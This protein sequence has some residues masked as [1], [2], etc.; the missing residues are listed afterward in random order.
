MKAI[1]SF[2]EKIVS[3]LD[4][5]KMSPNQ[6][7][8][9][10][11]NMR[12]FNKDGKG[13]IA[14]VL[15]GDDAYFEISNGFQVIGGAE[16]NGILYVVSYNES[17][18]LGEI[19]SYPGCENDTLVDRYV[20]F[21]NYSDG[22]DNQFTTTLFDFDLE[23]PVSV[24][25]KMS[26]DNSVDLYLVDNKNP[27][28]V[29]NSGF[30]QSGVS[31]GRMYSAEMFNGII[32]QIP[33]TTSRAAIVPGSLV[34]VGGKLKPGNYF[35]YLRYLTID[36][37]PTNFVSEIGPISIL[38]NT[39][40]NS[41]TGLQEKEWSRDQS[42]YT[43][44]KI[45]FAVSN[46]DTTYPYLELAVVRYSSL[47][48]NAAAQQDVF[49]VDKHYSTA[50]QVY[51]D[52]TGHEKEKTFTIDDIINDIGEY[53]ICK[54]QH[55][56]LDRWIGISWKKKDLGYEKETLAGFASLIEASDFH[57]NTTLTGTWPT[58][59]Q[60]ATNNV[61]LVA[62]QNSD[63]I[64]N[65]R[66]Y[67]KG[68][69]YPFAVQFLFQDG[70]L[71]EWYPIKG[72]L[73]TDG[74]IKG[75]YKFDTWNQV[76]SEK[77]NVSQ[78]YISGIQFD[79]DVVGASAKQ[80]I[81]DN[82]MSAVVGFR[83]GRG[84][85]IDNF[86]C[87]G[88]LFRGF[89]GVTI[90]E[91]GGTG[92]W[93]M[94]F[95][96]DEDEAGITGWDPNGAAVLPLLKGNFPVL[97]V[98]NSTEK[99][100]GRTMEQHVAMYPG[101][102]P[103]SPSGSTLPTKASYL[104]NAKAPNNK[105]G[106]YSPDILFEK[107]S[108]VQESTWIET[109]MTFEDSGM[110]S[111][112][113][114][115][116]KFTPGDYIFD[117]NEDNKGTGR[118]FMA[119]ASATAPHTAAPEWAQVKS[120]FVE[121]GQHKG[122]FGFSSYLR[123]I[124]DH[125]GFSR[126]GVDKNRD[127]YVARYLGIIDSAGALSNLFFDN[128]PGNTE[129]YTLVNLYKWKNDSSFYTSVRNSFFP[130]NT[131]YAPISDFIRI[132]DVVSINAPVQ[133]YGGDCF[134]Q[135]TWFRQSR[136]LTLD[137]ANSG[138]CA[139]PTFGGNQA[140][141][142]CFLYQHGLMVGLVTENKYNTAARNEVVGKDA[143]NEYTRYTYFPKV[144][145]DGLKLQEWIMELPSQYLIEAFQ[146]NDGYN[147]TLSD[148]RLY[149]YD[150]LAPEKDLSR[151][152][153]VYVSDQHVSGSY[154]DGYR[155]IS[156]FAFKDYAIELGP[157]VDVQ[158]VL[159]YITIILESGIIQVYVDEKAIQ[160]SSDG[161]IILGSTS[162]FLG[163]RVRELATFGSQHKSSIIQGINGVY[164]IDAR[165]RILWRVG[166]AEGKSGGF[167]LNAYDLSSALMVSRRLN[168][169]LSIHSEGDTILDK[170]PDL[171]LQGQGIVAGFDPNYKEVLFSFLFQRFLNNTTLVFDENVDGF[172]GEYSFARTAYFTLNN[173][174]LSVNSKIENGLY[175]GDKVIRKHNV[176]SIDGVSN[177]NRFNGETPTAMLTFVVNGLSENPKENVIA[178][179]KIFES[180]DVHCKYEDLYRL[181]YE[182]M[183]QTGIYL[184]QEEGS[185]FWFNSEYDLNK[186]NIPVA[187]QTSEDGSLFQEE[188]RMKGFW[189]KI[190][191]E[192]KG[193]N[194]LEIRS[195]ATNFTPIIS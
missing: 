85:R 185:E 93:D 159:D 115:I 9:P 91:N 86:I 102:D 186:W 56:F 132:D 74:E 122:K 120:T 181:V 162:R 104:L 146:I 123:A 103:S 81:L 109:L 78:K 178:I 20:P 88:V 8:F 29:I 99:W 69:I 66:G 154:I 163:D 45:R 195:V 101:L 47:Q 137:E 35:L 158:S 156:S 18:G 71:S 180:I 92:S 15:P 87:Q 121:T 117:L 10:T 75:L 24:L 57:E 89:W 40:H 100:Y 36:Y 28:R 173:A 39:G 127:I 51:I 128:V 167:Y 55:Q 52:Y 68:Q 64:L 184:F 94:T 54:A 147:K 21:K 37:A 22:T 144:L 170:W 79:L 5:S 171:P 16:H 72:Q 63:M 44:K 175:K 67:F 125:V 76:A 83:F 176:V 136:W 157:M 135:K 60:H 140:D 165:K 61:S 148:K 183:Y 38:N 19:G 166:R 129:R 2:T 118:I 3:D 138:E 113:S 6:W 77:N 193:N 116:D 95:D 187:V 105:L 97:T 149:G 73:D 194:D 43:D 11:V 155:K 59:Y 48:D 34:S 41:V 133:V 107:E 110:G 168:E 12:M 192:Y 150:A 151:P 14:S 90:D 31:N 172:R 23:H 17:N 32:N 112:I 84:D 7:T 130:R 62:Y 80:F 143:S 65:K 169:I 25:T 114:T 164:G 161:D 58:A 13:F 119:S 4:V 26:Y 190:T 182:T 131:M 42:L 98:E 179:E 160:S 174:L 106:L 53:T 96:T 82:D 33:S 124:G 108:Y 49:L 111:F 50:G 139:I 141:M 70:T 142:D 30:N 134:L 189:I 46:P 152:N 126:L 1:N 153:R 177:Y 27:N 145:D 188:S 191:I